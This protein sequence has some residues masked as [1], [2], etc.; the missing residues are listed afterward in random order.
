CLA[1]QG[2][3]NVWFAT[4]GASV[5]RVFRSHD[6]GR[7]WAVAETPMHPVNASSGIFS[8]AFADARFGVAAGGD[9]ANAGASEL[10]NIL[11][12]KDGGLSWQIGQQGTPTSF[13]I[14]G[15]AFPLYV[16]GSKRPAMTAVGITG[17]YF[18]TLNSNKSWQQK[19]Q[20]NLNAISGGGDWA[21]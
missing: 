9:Y 17:L 10:P 21:V 1:V 4:G 12:T 19:S 14:S 11:F 15:I 5:A 18:A 6:R 16:V 13:Y 8:L 7:H 20:E 2:S 3:R